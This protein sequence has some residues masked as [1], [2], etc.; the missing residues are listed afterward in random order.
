M[1][2]IWQGMDKAKPGADV[3]IVSMTREDYDALLDNLKV[4]EDALEFYA[5]VTHWVDGSR[6]Y[7]YEFHPD[8]W[9]LDQPELKAQA[10]LSKIKG[11][12]R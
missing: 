12:S 6:P 5:N 4:A 9:P 3:T 8:D 11:A 1:S 10:A 7:I 2:K